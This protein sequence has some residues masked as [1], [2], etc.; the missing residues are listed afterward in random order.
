M[1]NKILKIEEVTI[2]EGFRLEEGYKIVTE[3]NEILLLIDG[4]QQCCE[5]WGY[6]CTDENL[7]DYIGAEFIKY[8]EVY[9]KDLDMDCDNGGMCFLNIHTD[10]G[11][12]DFAVY[13]AH[14]GY[15]GHE[16]TL[17]VDGK[18]VNSAYI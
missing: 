7:E 4:Y 2:G 17:V 8:T 13:N 3:K 12:L 6:A 5:S 9:S 14:N 11:I 15:Y 16:A 10:R 1:S 18:I